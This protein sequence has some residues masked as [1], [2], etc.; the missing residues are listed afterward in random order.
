MCA[1]CISAFALEDGDLLPLGQSSVQALF[2]VHER[3]KGLCLIGTFPRR[4]SQQHKSN[5]DKRKGRLE[6]VLTEASDK[7]GKEEEP[8]SAQV[9]GEAVGEVA[10]QARHSAGQQRRF[11]VMVCPDAV[12]CMPSKQFFTKPNSI[13]DFSESRQ[14]GCKR[15]IQQALP[16]VVHQLHA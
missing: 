16:L 3:Q 15:V 10:D 11:V 6:Q 1:R 9:V 13:H 5:D 4:G 2:D 12:P 8:D 7:A 14:Q